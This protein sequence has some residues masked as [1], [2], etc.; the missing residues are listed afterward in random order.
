MERF[1]KSTVKAIGQEESSD[2]IALAPP[3]NTDIAT[4]QNVAHAPLLT[5]VR[6]GQAE[7]RI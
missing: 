4:R 3:K 1:L 7:S 2:Q 6:T 5:D